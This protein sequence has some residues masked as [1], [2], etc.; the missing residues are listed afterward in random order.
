[1]NNFRRESMV[2]SSWRQVVPVGDDAPPAGAVLPGGND[3]DPL[4]AHYAD[5]LD[6]WAAG[7]F[8]EFGLDVPS[9]VDVR[10]T[11]SDDGGGDGSGG[12]DA[13]SVDA[14]GDGA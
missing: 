4:S 11:A 13:S 9:G 10:F 6:D 1:V 12:G 5:Q 2:G 3:G 14:G 7:R 8:R